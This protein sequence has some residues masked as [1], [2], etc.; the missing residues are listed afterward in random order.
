MKKIAM[1]IILLL[2]MISCDSTRHYYGLANENTKMEGVE[3][4]IS[5]TNVILGILF[6]E[7][8]LVPTVYVAG[9]ALYESVDPVFPEE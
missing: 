2:T 6:L 5:P 7:V 9:W 8:A 3:Y 4:Q 1:V